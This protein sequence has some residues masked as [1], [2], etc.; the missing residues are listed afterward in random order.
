MT[1]RRTADGP[2]RILQ[3]LGSSAGGVARHVGQIS[4]ALSA[5]GDGGLGAEVVVAGPESVRGLVV[6]APRV[7]FAA[8]EI[9][10]RPRASDVSAVRA[11]RR[12][13]AGCDVLH[14]HGL[15]AGALAV[16]AARSLPRRARPRMVV[17][18]HNLPVG[19]RSVRAVSAVLETVVGR[20][21]DEV[22]GVSSDLVELARRRG[23][24]QAQRAL[25][26][27]PL[28]PASGRPG[29]D[30][31]A[32]RAGLGLE[33]D[34]RLLVTV[35][36][37]APQ[38]GLDTL[39]EAA[40][41]LLVAAPGLRFVWVVAGDG[42]LAG[43]LRADVALR[44]VPVRLLGAR[45]DAVDLMAAADVVVSTAV[46]EGQ[47]L[48]VQE[49][50]RVGAAVVATDAGGTREVTGD[51][52]VLVQVGD[53]RA[54]ATEIGALLADPGALGRRRELAVRRAAQLPTIDDVVSSLSHIY[55]LTSD[56]HPRAFD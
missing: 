1:E 25:V 49:A 36:R 23:A 32:V 3:V 19:S 16:L 8:V 27:A 30:A 29:G 55:R 22:L 4:A 39:C 21:A 28:A 48:G 34:E 53:A 44:A 37:L 10:D 6:T 26:P 17:T 47:P 45:T 7:G 50:L 5:T 12:L 41:Q 35:G 18:L 13:A 51:A 46:W 15:R 43:T 42:P 52:A 40:S 31:A 33:A 14:A 56:P 9:A 20:G 11:L 54:I 2:T 38:K 24:R